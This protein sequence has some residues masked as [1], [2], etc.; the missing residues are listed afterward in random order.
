MSSDGTI[1]GKKRGQNVN[2]AENNPVIALGRVYV[3]V[4][5]H[6]DMMVRFSNLRR[7]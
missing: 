3:H 2:T 5:S 1:C 6:N 4:Q 7:P